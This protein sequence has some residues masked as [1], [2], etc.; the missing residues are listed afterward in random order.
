M[1][2]AVTE[3]TYERHQRQREHIRVGVASREGSAARPSI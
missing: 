3:D 2:M 1:E